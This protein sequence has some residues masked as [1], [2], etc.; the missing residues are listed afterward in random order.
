[1]N[2]FYRNS[3]EISAFFCD[4]SENITMIGFATIKTG[5][6]T[7]SPTSTGSSFLLLPWSQIISLSLLTST[8]NISSILHC[9][10]SETN[11]WL[12]RSFII[13]DEG[14]AW[15]NAMYWTTT[16]YARAMGAS[17]LL[18]DIGSKSGGQ[19]P[20]EIGMFLVAD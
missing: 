7:L 17:L 12:R 10:A 2:S 5:T 16:G 1:M 14:S 8:D 19:F 11:H 13:T 9:F 15:I 6:K 20:F 18:S 4:D 3:E